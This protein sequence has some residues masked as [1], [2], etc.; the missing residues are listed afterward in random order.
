MLFA[1]IVA[2][3]KSAVNRKTFTRAKRNHLLFGK[4]A[5]REDALG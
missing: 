3:R 1:A 2:Q 5:R 4:R